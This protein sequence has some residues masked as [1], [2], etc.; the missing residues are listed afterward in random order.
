MD[1]CAAADPL[2]RSIEDAAHLLPAQGPIGVF[3]HHNTLHAFEGERFDEAV[4]HA[5]ALL[6]TEPFLAES[7]Y[8]EELARG[9]IRVA[10]APTTDLAKTN[11]D[12]RR[13]AFMVAHALAGTKRFQC[14]DPAVVQETL[15]AQKTR[16]EELLVRPERAVATANTLEVTGWLVPVL[17]ERGGV[18]YLDAVANRRGDKVLAVRG[19]CR[20]PDGGRMRERTHRPPGRHVPNALCPVGA[21]GDSAV[22]VGAE[23]CG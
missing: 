10:V 6:E 15:A 18:M 1:T 19:E 4:V 11:A 22:A 23:S 21:G 13:V 14:A 8:R 9:R 3:I 7:R 17:L 5:A 2:S 12:L 16:S 20:V